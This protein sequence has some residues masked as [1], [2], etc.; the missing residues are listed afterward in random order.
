MDD[1]QILQ[2]FAESRSQ[3]AF[4]HLVARHVHIVYSACLRQL[5]DPARADQATQAVF[6]ILAR[7]AA[8][9]KGEASLVPWLFDTAHEVC[10]LF[11][12]TTGAPDDQVSPSAV[13]SAPAD[14][15]RLSPQIDAAIASLPPGAREAFLLKY[16]ANFSLRDVATALNLADQQAGQRIAEGVARIRRSYESHN[17]FIA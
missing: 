14:W 12:R 6:V 8:R 3:E 10:N 13:Y 16:V 9:L 5:R 4:A 15:S 17:L 11:A 2:M 7:Q 1:A